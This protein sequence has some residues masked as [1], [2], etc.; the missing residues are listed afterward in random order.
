MDDKSDLTLGDLDWFVAHFPA[1]LKMSVALDV[2]KTLDGAH[3]LA[4]ANDAANADAEEAGAGVRAAA[5]AA[6]GAGAAAGSGSQPAAAAAAAASKTSAG[7]TAN[8]S[9]K[10]R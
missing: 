3:D 6:P 8:G 5:A 1:H 2:F 9:K 7:P 4:L 10:Q